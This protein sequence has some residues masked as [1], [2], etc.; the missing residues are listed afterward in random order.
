[1]DAMDVSSSDMPVLYR[2]CVQKYLN[3]SAAT[4]QSTMELELRISDE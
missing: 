1:M 4:R 2:C 3:S